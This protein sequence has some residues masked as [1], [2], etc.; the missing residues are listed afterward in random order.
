MPLT[1]SCCLLLTLGACIGVPL[2]SKPNSEEAYRKKF[3]GV[4]RDEIIAAYGA[5]SRTVK[6]DNGLKIMEYRNSATHVY[7]GGGREKNTCTLRFWYMTSKISHV[8]T[9]GNSFEPCDNMVFYGQRDAH[10]DPRNYEYK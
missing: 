5:P 3:V 8:D 1:L 7:K 6:L 2:Y 4:T 10:I 9:L